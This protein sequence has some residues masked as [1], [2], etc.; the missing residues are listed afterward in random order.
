[1]AGIEWYIG[2]LFLFALYG[3]CL[4]LAK[5]VCESGFALSGHGGV[6]PQILVT[7][8]LGSASMA[9][10]TITTLGILQRGCF[11]TARACLCRLWPIARRWVIWPVP[12]RGGLGKSM[13]AGTAGGYSLLYLF[14][15]GMGL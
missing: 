12:I 1:M 10:G 2:V 7:N 5:V 15:S 11:F 3:V 9:G 8:C 13:G 4:G 6:S 14:K